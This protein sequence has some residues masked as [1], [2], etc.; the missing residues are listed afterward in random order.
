MAEFS[1]TSFAAF[2]AGSV[3]AMEHSKHEALDRAAKVVQDEAK[4]VL[5]THDYN[6]PPL[7]S[8]T[9]AHK[10]NG[11]TPLL[12]TGELRDSI[13]RSVGH[14]E[15]V[16][17][18]DNDKALYHELGTSKIPPRP[19]LMGAAMHKEAE[20]RHILGAQALKGLITKP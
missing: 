2:L 4:R 19:F 11:D 9:I 5:G 20:V 13:K 6:W 8:E 12:E 15:A 16:V 7:K 18:S 17:G 3:A 14:D 1:L 10:A